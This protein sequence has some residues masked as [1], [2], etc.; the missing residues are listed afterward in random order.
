MPDIVSQNRAGMDQAVSEALRDLIARHGRALLDDPRRCEALLR[1]HCPDARRETAVLVGAL[2][3]GV[4]QRLLGLPPASLTEATV[5]GYAARLTEELAMAEAAAQWSVM[6]WASAFRLRINDSDVVPPPMAGPTQAAATPAAS[7][8]PTSGD[9]VG[10]RG[11]SRNRL[12]IG[13]IAAGAVALLCIFIAL[14]TTQHPSPTQ[15]TA[16]PAPRPA[17]TPTPSPA[18][19]APM[20]APQQPASQ[21]AIPD[22]N[23][24]DE[25]A[26][27]GVPPQNFLQ[28]NVGRPT[29]TTIPGGR[30][31]YTAQLYTALSKNPNAAILIDALDDSGHPTLPDANWLPGVGEGGNLN[32]AATQE[33]SSEL[34][35]LTG[36]NRDRTLVFFCEGARCWESYNAA[37]RAIH[38]GFQ[39]VYWYRG[40]LN[41]WKEAGLRLTQ[42]T[43]P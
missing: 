40:G 3:E 32:D 11:L 9:L 7:A 31:V 10:A 42:A 8:A 38:L 1:D 33:L 2:R 34:T 27:F 21:P 14:E 5:S 43:R 30:V 26:D 22:R 18:K 20:P 13:G 41:A 16:T 19:P 6:T 35:I 37:L 39:A 4:P 17:P 23:Y 25:H 28:T 15:P 36:G 12:V 29:P 24:A